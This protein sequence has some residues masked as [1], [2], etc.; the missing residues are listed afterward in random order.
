MDENKKHKI[1]KDGCYL[2][3]QQKDE[4]Y[5]LWLE[6]YNAYEAQPRKENFLEDIKDFVSKKHGG[7]NLYQRL[8]E[9]MKLASYVFK[10]GMNEHQRYKYVTHDAVTKVAREALMEVG[11]KAIPTDLEVQRFPELK[12]VTTLLKMSVDFINVDD[13]EDHREIISYGEGT[14]NQDKG[15]GKAKSYALKYAYLK[16]LGLETGLDPEQ[17]S[18]DRFEKAQEVKKTK[19]N[20][21]PES[22]SHKKKTI[23]LILELVEKRGTQEELNNYL[24]KHG[25]KTLYE[26]PE[27]N[28]NAI[29]ESLLKKE[30]ELI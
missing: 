9:A 27:V 17:D 20:P 5:E 8:N 29:M 25:F 21:S 10:D 6:F 22:I 24:A 28:L 7:M 23:A 11:V 2:N 15:I 1:K 13:P 19:V 26:L 12:S 4:L 18:I 30:D 3:K 14:D 16:I